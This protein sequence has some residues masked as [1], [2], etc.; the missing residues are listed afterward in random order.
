LHRYGARQL[1]DRELQRCLDRGSRIDHEPA[2][3]EARV[4]EQD[5]PCRPDGIA[6]APQQR[7]RID[8]MQH[9]EVGRFD[10]VA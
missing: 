4:K 6:A 3:H 7:L 9:P 2:H 5:L 8:L 10:R 1:E